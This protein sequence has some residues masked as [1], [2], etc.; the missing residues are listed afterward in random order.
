MTPICYDSA[1]DP[2]LDIVLLVLGS[3]LVVGALL[4]A[5]AERSFL[6]LTALFVLVGFAIGPGGFNL[7]E[8]PVDS[9]FVADLAII[10]L[11][12]ILFRDG[13]EIDAQ[14]IRR[15]WRL[16]L[17]KLL[18]AMPLTCLFVALAAKGLFS[19]LSWLEA[20]LIGA[21]LAP[22]DPVLTSSIVGNRRVPEKIRNSLSLESGLNDGLALPVILA[23]TVALGANASSGEDFV[24]WKFILQD[25][26]FGVIYGLG[27]GLLGGL[28]LS[29]PDKELP[30][31]LKALFGL[32]FGLFAYSLAHIGP[33][34]NG[35]IAV[36]VCA[37]VLGIR[38]P[39]LREAVVQQTDDVAEI[40][41][42]GVFVVFGSLLTLSGLFSEGIIMTGLFIAAC[43][44]I[45]RPLAILI[46]L[47]GTRGVD[48]PT[49]LFIGWFGPKGIAT[50]AFGLIVLSS[51]ISAGERIFEIAGVV[52][53][54]SILI[55]GTTDTV[56]ARW[57]VSRSKT[58]ESAKP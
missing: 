30:T 56:G 58:R 39:D 10:T 19:E 46:A 12:V 33:H 27:L 32:G 25:I 1:I 41:K 45:A 50:M 22:T 5:L 55:H 11:V 26:G 9:L 23:L 2:Q 13:L 17:R 15:G 14:A 57:I 4:S 35:L 3:L 52:V 18:I 24:L 42:L 44:L 21:L 31:H 16:P 28:L 37:I 49:K 34:G 8:F 43:F 29:I 20:F 54:F 53:F 38:R 6:S 40:L 48:L 51:G 36:F 7:V 47:T